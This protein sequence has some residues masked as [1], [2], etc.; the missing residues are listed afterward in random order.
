MGV[1]KGNVMRRIAVALGIAVLLVACGSSAAQ[2]DGSN[3]QGAPAPTTTAAPAATSPAPASTQPGP[4]T[5]APPATLAAPDTS[6]N[7]GASEAAMMEVAPYFFIDEAG[8]S[9][10]TGPFLVPVAREVEA[11]KAVARAAIEELLAGP[12]AGELEAVP[13]L[14]SAIPDDVRLLGLTIE[15]GVAIIDLS[16][17]FEIEDDS[18]AVAARVAQVVFTLTRFDSVDRVRFLQAGNEVKAPT[19][20]GGLIAGAVARGDYLDFA[21]AISVEGP[22][23]GGAVSDKVRV[24]GFAAVFEATFRYALAD[25]DGLIIEEGIAMTSNGMGW[26]TFDFTIDYDLDAAQRGTLIVWVNS[27]KDGSRIDIREYPLFLQP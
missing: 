18:A 21:A 5:T 4:A 27:A 19:S 22:I 7:T 6:P 11:T 2:V 13:A 8:H 25:W 12:D 3:L 15:D 26:G 9:H 16:S 23:H 20:D 1:E 24:T 14:S 17:E 10:R